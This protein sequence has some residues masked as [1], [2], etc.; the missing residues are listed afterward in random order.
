MKAAFARI[1]PIFTALLALGGCATGPK[2]GAAGGSKD[3]GVV[4]VSYEYAGT[5]P[6][7]SVAKAD[8]IA[9]NRCGDWGYQRAALIPGQVRDCVNDEGDRCALM[10][11]TREYKCESE[12][13]S[14]ASNLA[15]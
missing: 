5:E 6:Q 8:A 11:V 15:R 4:R 2:W 1:A 14:L 10:K 7:M 9:E 13:S 3:L 12:R